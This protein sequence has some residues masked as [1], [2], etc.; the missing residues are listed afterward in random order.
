M[1]GLGAALA[2]ILIAAGLVAVGFLV[3]MSMAL[4]SMGSNK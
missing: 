4:S 1:K 2:V 3:F